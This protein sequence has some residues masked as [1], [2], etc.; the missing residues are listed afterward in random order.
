MPTR[1]ITRALVVAAL[2][3][4]GLVAIVG[5]VALRGPGVVAVGVA[6][7]LAGC[8]GWGMA[9]E[10]EAPARARRSPAEVA[11]LAAAWTVGVLLALS[12][13]SVL[14][15]GIAAAV[16][17]G[18]VATAGIV[19]WMVRSPAEA[20]PRAAAP[21]GSGRVP[22]W[23]GGA[24]V[25]G[26]ATSRRDPAAPAAARLFPPVSELSTAALGEEWVHST[27]ALA[28]PL[29]SSVRQSVVRRRQEA[30][31]ELER[32]DPDGFARWLAA[33]PESGSDPAAFV[34]G[35]EAAGTDAA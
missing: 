7:A 29:E 24:D 30:L 25:I 16:L 19:F 5:G 15:G 8:L 22:W 31:D 23:M 34:G 14:A 18:L 17:A 3:A 12:G 32:R 9:R 21:S 27:A 35:G 2:S 26:A 28:G 11:V 4:G 33:G 13:V 1:G 10:A 6:G 20:G